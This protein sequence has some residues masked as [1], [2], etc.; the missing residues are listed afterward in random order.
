MQTLRVIQRL[1]AK[2][3]VNRFKSNTI[4]SL[5]SSFSP[6]SLSQSISWLF[7]TLWSLISAYFPYLWIP[8]SFTFCL[9]LYVSSLSLPFPCFCFCFADSL[10]V[11]FLS[12]PYSSVSLFLIFCIHTYFGIFLHFT[13]FFLWSHFSFSLSFV[14]LHCS[15]SP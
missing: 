13:G 11:S 5:C 1:P 3:M 15:V 8:L 7:L 4:W 10:P 9:R 12:P 6:L 2:G 14:A